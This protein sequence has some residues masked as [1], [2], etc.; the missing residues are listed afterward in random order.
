VSAELGEISQLAEQIRIEMKEIARDLRP[1]HLDKIGL[2]KA[3]AKMADRVGRAC[4]LDV[5]TD[6]AA[7]DDVVAPGSRIHIYR[8]VQEG[9]S[10]VVKH[11]DASQATV[12]VARD[13]CCIHIR[14]EDDGQGLGAGV[15][16]AARPG[17]EGLGLMGIRERTRMLGGTIEIRSGRCEGT[18]L[19]L[20]FPLEGLRRGH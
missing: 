17:G 9:L 20:T 15:A 16:D 8:I 19:I 1:Y 4:G 12:R 14:V 6:I 7:I 5:A 10:N 18:A 11:A 3:I 13:A 2:T